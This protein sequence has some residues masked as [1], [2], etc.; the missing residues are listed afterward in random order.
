L[1]FSLSVLPHS[2]A[3][4]QAEVWRQALA[5]NNPPRSYT[6]AMDK[7]GRARA[8]GTGPSRRSFLAVEGRNAV[9][10]A[11]KKAEAGEALILRLYNPSVLPTQAT[12]RLPF[13]P[14]RVALAGLDE[15]PR[16]AAGAESAPVL[17]AGGRVRVPLP[18]GKIITLRMERV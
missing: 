10:S 15:Q 1:T 7:A 13:V 5:H 18:P 2:G 9:L 3:W 11:L 6:T 12:V 4:D 16:E 8:H 17:E 14:A